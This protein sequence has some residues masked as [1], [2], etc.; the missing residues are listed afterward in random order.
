MTS[1]PSDRQSRSTAELKRY[2]LSRFVDERIAKPFDTASQRDVQNWVP[3]H[4]KSAA[5]QAL[6]EMVA[7]SGPIE[8]ATSA[9]TYWLVDIGDGQEKLET[10]TQQYPHWFTDEGSQ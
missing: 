5:L 10:L 1:S 3:D 6:M 8:P 7:S 2:I 9:G 4:E